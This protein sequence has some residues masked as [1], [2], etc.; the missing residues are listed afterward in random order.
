MAT[1]AA[2]C[3]SLLGRTCTKNEAHGGAGYVA[4]LGDFGEIFVF[5]RKNFS[6]RDSGL[7]LHP[8]LARGHFLARFCTAVFPLAGGGSITVSLVVSN[9]RSAPK[10]SHLIG[11]SLP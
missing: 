5:F 10:A 7:A 1:F 9:G 3:A 6:L 11:S 8:S 2:R 4:L